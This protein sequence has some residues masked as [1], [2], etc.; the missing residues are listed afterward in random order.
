MSKSKIPPQ[1]D[2]AGG[3]V[4][5]IVGDGVDLIGFHDSLGFFFGDSQNLK[6]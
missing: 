6:L 5:E 3:Q 4:G 2:R 1:L